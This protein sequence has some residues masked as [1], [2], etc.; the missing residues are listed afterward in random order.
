MKHSLSHFLSTGVLAISMMMSTTA[1]ADV[2]LKEDFN[3]PV[4]DLYG[5]G[6]WLQSN[7]KSNAIR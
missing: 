6:G 2:L 3:Y 7:N 4:G 1:S 5:R